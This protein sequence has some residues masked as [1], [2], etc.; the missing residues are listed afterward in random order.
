MTISHVEVYDL[1]MKPAKRFHAPKQTPPEKHKDMD[2]SDG[3]LQQARMKVLMLPQNAMFNRQRGRALT[4]L[5]SIYWKR[6]EFDE[7]ISIWK[8]LIN[9]SH[10]ENDRAALGLSY[11][12]LATTYSQKGEYLLAIENAKKALAYEPNVPTVMHMLGSAYD[13]AGD[14]DNAFLW[15]RRLIK[16]HPT[17]QFTYEMIGGLHFRRGEFVEA[18]KFLLKALELEPESDVGI[19]ELG[20]MYVTLGR[21]EEAL[22]R[23][24]DAMRLHPDSASAYNN[25][26]NCYMK[27]GRYE[28]SRRMYLK[29][30]EVRARDALSAH[31]GLGMISRLEP[32]PK[33]LE[34]SVRY[35][36]RGLEIYKSGKAR[37]LARI[38]EHEARG[39]IILTGLSDP[40]C[41]EVWQT[42]LQNSEI[43][44]V[45]VGPVIDWRFS[46]DLMRKSP[47][48]PAQI[49]EVA[50]ILAARY[51]RS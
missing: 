3:A 24:R 27:M 15:W 7:A 8:Q 48:P 26:G 19:N 21:Y 30:I 5:A 51:D 18:E 9:M 34:A 13:A 16:Q 45:G 37:L 36:Q 17:F 35:F 47:H 1:L 44:K 28:E 33:A 42:L 2:I 22:A 25:A 32:T 4:D 40:S 29:R 31:I 43:A 39:A 49:E 10:Q 41:V 50:Q 11:A 14:D 12:A 23:F 20:N 6:L 38:I 46:V